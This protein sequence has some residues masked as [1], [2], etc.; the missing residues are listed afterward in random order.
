MV[1]HGWVLPNLNL[2][3]FLR[4]MR[5]TYARTT[6]CCETTWSP[7]QP[8]SFR[9]LKIKKFLGRNRVGL[10]VEL[11][12]LC[13][14]RISFQSGNL[15]YIFFENCFLCNEAAFALLAV[16]CNFFPQELYERR[17]GKKTVKELCD[18]SCVLSK[19]LWLKNWDIEGKIS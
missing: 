13:N 16:T 18:V 10:G 3:P 9:Q 17:G 4:C 12:S 14:M 8:G 6:P 7:L 2:L 1:F 5:R 19:K 15:D 11:S